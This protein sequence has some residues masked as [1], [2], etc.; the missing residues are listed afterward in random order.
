MQQKKFS[1][2]GNLTG[3]IV[4]FFA[5]STAAF[6]YI[7]ALPAGYQ[8]EI[9]IANQ[10]QTQAR[11]SLLLSQ[12][13]MEGKASARSN[14]R[15]VI[16]QYA[17]YL[18]L[19]KN[20]GSTT[21][22]KNSLQ[23]AGAKGPV[24]EKVTQAETVWREMETHFN[25][26]LN[27]RL[28]D[29]DGLQ[30]NATVQASRKHIDDHAH[31]WHTA[32][33]QIVQAFFT[34]EKQLQNATLRA[35]MVAFS[36]L[37]IVMIAGI[38]YINTGI[39]RPVQ[40]LTDM[41]KR[42]NEGHYDEDIA[43][44]AKNELGVLGQMLN[45]VTHK[46]RATTAFVE[47]LGKGN[48]SYQLESEIRAGMENDR[49]FSALQ[50]TQDELK[51]VEE[52]NRKR[53][54]SNEGISTIS[55]M[56]QRQ[57]DDIQELYD[58]L[59]ATIIQYVEAN[60]GAIFTKTTA[61]DQVKLEMKGCYAY[62][63]KKFLHETFDAE[64]GLLG[65]SYKEGD[66][67]VLTEIPDD[68]VQITSGMG[69]A[70]PSCL[71]LVPLIDNEDKVGIIEIALFQKIE[72]HKIDFLKR[73]SE[74]IAS[75][76]NSIMIN[77]RTKELLSESQQQAEEMRAQEEEMRQNM[78]EL[79]A[80]QEEMARKENEINK[81]L[82]ASEAN[83]KEL[84]K[85]IRDSEILQEEMELEN[86]MFSTLMDMLSDRITIKDKDGYYMRV[87]KAK[88]EVLEQQGLKDVIGSSDKELFGEEHYKRSLAVEQKVIQSGQ[89]EMDKEDEIKMP[90]GQIQWGA[91]SR[92]PFTNKDGR[93]LG[94]VVVT[95]NI[96]QEK[97]LQAELDKTTALTKAIKQQQEECEKDK[98]KMQ[99]QLEGLKK[100]GK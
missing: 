36:V 21:F 67:M 81:L 71:V 28:N 7:A 51:Q 38:T 31:E 14:C 9:H 52:E 49:L 19:L 20:G 1:L 54:W 74:L 87:N 46:F 57:Y 11:Q 2:K 23:I 35:I 8:A 98:K 86:A 73:I 60:Q 75:A 41:V 72:D 6:A 50:Q 33:S 44:K 95:R 24:K 29:S 18:S 42:L 30:N 3:I 12:L 65:Q 34:A 10:L 64:E 13:V 77:E 99:K 17:E 16:D 63:R 82:E 26:I 83:Q 97:Q 58:K 15:A 85:K 62:E 78:E 80:T 32:N 93:T 94:S 43:V 5:I 40:Y 76:L 66:M 59:I 45:R 25:T 68:Y 56:L 96:T 91:T 39:A 69:A 84:E 79:Q 55:E 88:A 61:G 53:Q 47:E 90:D 89:P 22:Q 92:A 4:L 48:L 37:L 70:T 100:G 27:S